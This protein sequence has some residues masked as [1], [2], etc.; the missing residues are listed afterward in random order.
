MFRF[1]PDGGKDE[2]WLISVLVKEQELVYDE[3]FI[4]KDGNFVL[5]Q[6]KYLTSFL[7]NKIPENKR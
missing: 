5:L 6:W 4:K 1:I 7:Q 2:I 3:L